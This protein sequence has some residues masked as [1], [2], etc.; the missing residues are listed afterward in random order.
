MKRALTNA[1]FQNCQKSNSSRL[2]GGT[3]ILSIMDMILEILN[4]RRGWQDIEQVAT[5]INV[6]VAEVKEI[7]DFMAEYGFVTVDKTGRRLKLGYLL[8]EFLEEISQ[9]ESEG[10]TL[11]T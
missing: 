8:D 5:R 11:K 9:V 6:S 7:I 2:S 3:K 10:L 1:L 4:E